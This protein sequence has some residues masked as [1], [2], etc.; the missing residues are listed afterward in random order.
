[1]TREETGSTGPSRLTSSIE[2]RLNK[3]VFRHLSSI[4]ENKHILETLIKVCETKKP[5]G[6]ICGGKAARGERGIMFFNEQC[7]TESECARRLSGDILAEMI[8]SEDFLVQFYDSFVSPAFF[9]DTLAGIE[10][11][12][13]LSRFDAHFLQNFTNKLCLGNPK[14]F[15][16]TCNDIERRFPALES[17]G[18]RATAQFGSLF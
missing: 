16:W 18:G 8:T 17:F 4:L 7:L 5:P 2:Q 1:M 9:K 11:R 12:G 15:H 13:S 14:A 6:L 3:E 10:N